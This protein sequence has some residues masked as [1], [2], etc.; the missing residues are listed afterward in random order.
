[1]KFQLMGRVSTG[2]AVNNWRSIQRHM[3][4]M[5]S[6]SRLE[7]SYLGVR[8]GLREIEKLGREGDCD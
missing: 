6:G 2:S 5:R 4:P 7:P 3:S 8:V 1:M